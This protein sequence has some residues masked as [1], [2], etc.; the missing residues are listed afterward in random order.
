MLLK[1]LILS[2]FLILPRVSTPES[3]EN[4]IKAQDKSE[5]FSQFLSH[6]SHGEQKLIKKIPALLKS[7]YE[8]HPLPYFYA[9]TKSISTPTFTSSKTQHFL[10]SSLARAPPHYS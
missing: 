9:V 2:L 4:Y 5:I 3:A 7:F 1:L 10:E 6:Q 8:E